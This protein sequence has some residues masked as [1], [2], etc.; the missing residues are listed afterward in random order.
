[1]RCNRCATGVASP[2]QPI[3]LLKILA[4]AAG[5]FFAQ[6]TPPGWGNS[7]I[8]RCKHQGQYFN[9]PRY[10]AGGVYSFVFYCQNFF[11]IKCPLLQTVIAVGIFVKTLSAKCKK[12][13]FMGVFSCVVC[14]FFCVSSAALNNYTKRRGRS[15]FLFWFLLCPDR[16][17]LLSMLSPFSAPLLTM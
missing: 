13:P 8:S 17:S 6:K 14:V 4:P 1:M 16:D 2:V 7:H 10:K 5:I 9:A 12:T 15:L 3:E 11:A